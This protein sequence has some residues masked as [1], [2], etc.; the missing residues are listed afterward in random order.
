M[1]SLS[2][3]S[4]LLTLLS[5][6]PLLAVDIP[7]NATL[8]AALKTAPTELSKLAL[9]NDSLEFDFTKSEKYT[10]SPGGV[11]NANAATFPA[12]TG[13]GLTIA[14]LA[15]G[16]CAMLPPHFHPRATNFVVAV[17]G[18]TT[19]YMV[20]ENGA[21]I[22][23]TNLTPGK[24]TIFP[25]GSVHSMQNMGCTNAT[26]ISALNSDDTGTTNLLNALFQLPSDMVDAAFGTNGTSAYGGA[27]PDI[28]TGAAMGSAE[29][30]ARCGL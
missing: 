6:T 14:W 29:C 12:S 2:P 17:E 13:Q 26:L 21:K 28:G 4:L 27:V 18:E 19:T 7:I 1:F 24:M 16:P 23:T 22:V 10:Y 8:N 9:I 5:A 3:K 25:T 11:V 15:L 20:Q 30:R